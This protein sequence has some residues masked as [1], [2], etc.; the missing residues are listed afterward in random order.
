MFE[1]LGDSKYVI[2]KENKRNFGHRKKKNI[3]LRVPSSEES[4]EWYTSLQFYLNVDL[5]KT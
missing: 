4:F 3:W 5:V 2:W 1:E